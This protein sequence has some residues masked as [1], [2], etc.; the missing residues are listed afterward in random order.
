MEVHL[1]PSPTPITPLTQFKT[2]S[3]DHYLESRSRAGLG[4]SFAL[5]SEVVLH[6][7]D[8][9]MTECSFS[10]IAFWRNGG[11]VTPREASGGLPGV[12]RRWLLERDVW[13]EGTVRL[14]EVTRGERVLLSNALRGVFVGVIV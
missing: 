1:D 14:D 5:P 8:G 7:P 3:R 2:T 4:L 13:R 9:E 6:N 12:M 11:W 10:N